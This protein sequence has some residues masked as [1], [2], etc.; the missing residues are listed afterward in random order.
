MIH[1]ERL[2]VM[3]AYASTMLSI[4]FPNVTSDGIMYMHTSNSFLASNLYGLEL[5][6]QAPVGPPSPGAIFS[7]YHTI[8]TGLFARDPSS[9]QSLPPSSFNVLVL[10]ED[11][12]GIATS[13][14]FSCLS[15]FAP[16]SK[17]MRG[18]ED[19]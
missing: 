7:Y 13:E 8:S 12:P 14:G 10:V 15:S 18:F 17:N 9:G 4:R 16:P 19:D 11:P 1:R 5:V 6:L 2:D 3:W